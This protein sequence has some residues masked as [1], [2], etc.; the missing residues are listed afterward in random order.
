MIELKHEGFQ[1][2]LSP[3]MG[4]SVAWFRKDGIDI[5]RP[6]S[7]PPAGERWNPLDTA[8]FPLFPFSGR[9]REGRF[10]WNGRDIRLPANF[11]P[12]R[13]A[14]HGQSWQAAWTATQAGPCSATLT[15]QH[16]A[17]DWPWSYLAEQR[18]VLSP[19]GLSLD[20]S[21]T[22]QSNEAMPAGIGWHPYFP[23]EDARLAA[24][25]PHVWQ[26]DAERLPTGRI[27]ASPM[28][29]P[30]A[31]RP[32]DD[33]D[34]DHPFEME[35]G[36]I[37]LTWPQRRLHIRMHTDDRLRFMIL[38]IPPGQDF[39]CAEPVSHVPDMVNLDAPARQTG[40]VRLEPGE[41]LRCSLS[42]WAEALP[43]GQTA[44]AIHAPAG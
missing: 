40:L 4:G 14:I 41:T 34:L 21:L 36:I 15:Y 26:P 24:R 17:G 32:V 18:F 20:L 31:D 7:P 28:I 38:Y 29:A 27:T 2:G 43:A 6:A 30:S 13:H 3:E 22:N 25:L 35:D 23:R 10:G 42:L 12:E 19:G 39:F 11:P 8:A 44:E 1:L 16:K 33:Y 5:L 9:I 37:E